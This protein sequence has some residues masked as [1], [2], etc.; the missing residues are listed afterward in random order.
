[1]RDRFDGVAADL[2]ALPDDLWA[3]RERRA[4][5]QGRPNDRPASTEGDEHVESDHGQPRGAETLTG[6]V[7]GPEENPR[8][9]WDDEPYES[10]LDEFFA[11][12]VESVHFE[13]LDDC[14]WYANIRLND[15]QMWT[16]NFGSLS[17]RAR[18]FANAE[19]VE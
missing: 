19:Q 5:S 18:G 7:Y 11:T 13:A 2:D 6:P 12:N 3:A 8:I 15:G 4:L 10:P 1:M 17:G 14:R 16:L 9:G